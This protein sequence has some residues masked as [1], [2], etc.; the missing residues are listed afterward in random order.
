MPQLLSLLSDIVASTQADFS[1]VS[2]HPVLCDCARNACFVNLWYICNM[3][4]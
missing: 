1:G 4:C 3:E 2:K